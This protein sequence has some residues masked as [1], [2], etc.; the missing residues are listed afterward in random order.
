MQVNHVAMNL[1]TTDGAKDKIRVGHRELLGV[2]LSGTG[3]TT[4]N[5]AFEYTNDPLG[6][7]GWSALN[8]RNGATAAY[9]ATAVA[10]VPATPLSLFFD[11]D[12]RP[13][14]IRPVVSGQ[15]GPVTLSGVLY[16]RDPN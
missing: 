8:F 2:Y 14:W 7:S 9:A 16:T 3:G 15:T 4:A 10:V 6:L 11:P 12:N 13:V 1:G 5:V